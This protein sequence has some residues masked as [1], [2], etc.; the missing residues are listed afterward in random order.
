M[1]S[2][3]ILA[4][5]GAILLG[6]GSAASAQDVGPPSELVD[7][8]TQ[9]ARTNLAQ[10]R[11]SDGSNVPPETP[12][13]LAQP[14]VPR[15]LEVQTIERALLSAAME[16]C[17]DDYSTLSYQP[18]M[19]TLRAS[20]RYSDKQMAYIGLLHGFAMGWLGQDLEPEMCSEAFS[21]VMEEEARTA[22]IAT[23]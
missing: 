22:P 4:A 3:A 1:I 14:L 20:G 17:G 10:A 12:E 8:L 6:V 18:Y 23:P 13:E 16:T 15:A 11:L 5:V 7:A 2:R 19:S 21:A 9:G